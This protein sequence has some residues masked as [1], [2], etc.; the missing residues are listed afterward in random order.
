DVAA[1]AAAH[2]IATPSVT[3]LVETLTNLGNGWVIFPLAAVV[4]FSL[5]RAR[6]HRD[7]VWFAAV[8]VGAELFGQTL[9]A[10]FQRSRPDP[11]FGSPP[12]GSYSFPSG[13]ALLSCA[14]YLA[15]AQLTTAMAWP[16]ALK[17]AAWI[18]AVLL[19]LGIG[20]SRVYLGVHYPT[21][22]LAGYAA[23]IAWTSILK[24]TA[25]RHRP[26]RLR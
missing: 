19:T 2:S 12:P 20:F 4:V 8:V 23:A 24:L 11:F 10:I 5:A 1:R 9:K 3:I 22:V 16:R 26:A 13:H 17:L 25:N 15:L 14:F 6:R 7:A 21:D 18:L